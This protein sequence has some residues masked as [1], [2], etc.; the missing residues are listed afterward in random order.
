MPPWWPV[1]GVSRTGR[2]SRVPS[3]VWRRYP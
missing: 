2:E 3:A 1:A